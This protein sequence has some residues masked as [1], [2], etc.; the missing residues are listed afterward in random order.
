MARGEHFWSDEQADRSRYAEREVGP[1]PGA[2]TPEDFAASAPPWSGERS[3]KRE[4]R[5]STSL[6]EEQGS[7]MAPGQR[8]SIS[9]C[10][11]SAGTVLPERLIIA[12][13]MTS[14]QETG[15]PNLDRDRDRKVGRNQKKRQ[16]GRE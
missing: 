2:A 6:T 4:A 8:R 13:L 9:G 1:E 7:A 16:D 11:Y 10:R 3:L 15:K 14:L 12:V 5:A